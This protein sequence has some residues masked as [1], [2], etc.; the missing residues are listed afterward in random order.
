MVSNSFFLR[1]VVVLTV[2]SLAALVTGKSC[3]GV[4]SYELPNVQVTP[5][6]TGPTTGSFNVLVRAN[7]G[8]LPKLISAFNVDF[9]VSNTL[10]KIGPASIPSVNPL[11]S[12][13][14][15][16]QNPLFVDFSSNNQ[17]VRI[18]HDAPLNQDRPLGDGKALVTVPFSVPAGLTGTFP[19]TFGANQFNTLVDSGANLVPV[20]LTDVGQ[21]TVMS[22]PAGVAG[23]YNNNGIVDAA[24]YVLWRNNLGTSFALPNEVSGVTPGTVT[25]DDYNAWRVRFGRTSGSGASAALAG[26]VPEP[27]ALVLFLLFSFLPAFAR[28]T[29]Q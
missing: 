27:S 22:T 23:D 5:A 20:N 26:A 3:F 4:I 29:R 11:L 15:T 25:S 24:D 28:P 1:R 18:G 16:P 14:G 8:D 6:P 10:V 7:P 12:D 17:N 13:P 21:I 2:A 19:I 9:S